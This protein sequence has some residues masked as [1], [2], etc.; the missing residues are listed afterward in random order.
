MVYA[1]AL[2]M[3]APSFVA[4]VLLP[5]SSFQLAPLVDALLAFPPALLG[6]LLLQA[7]ASFHCLMLQLLMHAEDTHTADLQQSNGLNMLL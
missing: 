6:L 7:S 1:C 5:L 4:R 2:L 3:A